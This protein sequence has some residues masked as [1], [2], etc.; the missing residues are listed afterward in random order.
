MDFSEKKKIE[1]KIR[2]DRNDEGF[3]KKYRKVVKELDKYK[4]EMDECKINDEKGFLNKNGRKK[5]RGTPGKA[6]HNRK[7][8]KHNDNNKLNTGFYNNKK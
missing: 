5:R 3:D 6:L 4:I 1:A 2:K 8:D 7:L